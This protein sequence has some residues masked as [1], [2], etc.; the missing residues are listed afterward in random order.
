LLGG[1]FEAGRDGDAFRV[2][3]TLPRPLEALS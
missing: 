3:A 1:R 2:V